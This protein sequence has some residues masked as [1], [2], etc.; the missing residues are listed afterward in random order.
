M[1]LNGKRAL[2]TGATTTLGQTAAEALVR[3]GADL[4]LSDAT[5]LSTLVDRL[6]RD[7]AGRKVLNLPA[8]ENDPASVEEAVRRAEEGLGAIDILVVGSEGHV[9]APFL[10]TDELLWDEMVNA[11]LRSA[12][13]WCRAVVPRMKARKR[14]RIVL[15]SAL[16][17]RAGSAR[18]EVAYA[19]A[20]GGL[21]G[22]VHSLSRELA[23]VDVSVN[24][25]V[26]GVMPERFQGLTH[27]EFKGALANTPLQRF[28]TADDLVAPLLM[29][30]SDEGGFVRGTAVHVNGGFYTTAF[31]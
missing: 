8:D 21:L 23:G 30:V 14:G 24:A 18:G 4:A 12:F 15:F 7:A 3:E 6:A 19:T 5:D 11:N 16:E 10:E 17:A 13:Y 1:R 29:L 2:I 9:R 22:L 20:K 25:I 27:E 31:N 26:P 28:C